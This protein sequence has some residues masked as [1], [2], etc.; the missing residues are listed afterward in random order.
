MTLTTA[1]QATLKA[2]IVATPELNAFPN[3]EDGAAGIANLL[4]TKT[5][6]D[7]TVWKTNVQLDDV[8]KALVIGISGLTTSESGRIDLL[9]SYSQAGVDPSDL[10]IGNP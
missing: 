1:Q 4:N 8:G 5:S 9:A 3:N 6:P 10:Q 2:H 7:F